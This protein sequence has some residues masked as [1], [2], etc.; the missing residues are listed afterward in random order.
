MSA[1]FSITFTL[2]DGSVVALSSPLSDADATRFATWAVMDTSSVPTELDANGVAIP[3]TVQ[4]ALTRLSSM[5]LAQSFASLFAWE[6][7]KALAAVAEPTPITVV[8]K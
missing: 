3:R 6:H 5:F 4:W 8:I 7:A 1:S 2:T